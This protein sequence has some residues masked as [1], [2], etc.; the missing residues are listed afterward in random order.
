MKIL[1]IGTGHM[2]SA[3]ISGIKSNNNFKEQIFVFNRTY[4]K[5]LDVSKKYNVIPVKK[6][7][8]LNYDIVVLG[9]RPADFE[10]LAVDLKKFTLEKQTFVTMINALS[11]KQASDI[12]GNNKLNIVR[13]MP[14]MNAAIQQS[15][16]AYS[17]NKINSEVTKFVI[18]MFS[19]C[20]TVEEIPEDKFPAFTAL[21]GCSPS[22]IFT[23]LNG[24]YKYALKNGFSK[25]QAYR[26]MKNTIIGSTEYSTNSD[27]SFDEL[28]NSICVPNGSTIEGQKVL[29]T[30]NF[31]DIIIKA[32]EAA[33]QKS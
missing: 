4:E 3:L 28:I 24:F 33:K 1:F 31:Q 7:E 5:S 22:Y 8:H 17:S 2:G 27:N 30:N 10:Q 16:T 9:I 25:D 15:V 23:F 12:F 29:E 13:I 26:I 20:G 18:E 21:A 6:L 14:N 32:L 19:N 11:I